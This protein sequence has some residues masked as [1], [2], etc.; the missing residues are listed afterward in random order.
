MAQAYVG[1]VH[2]AAGVPVEADVERLRRGEQ[3]D[4]LL[5][6]VR[7]LPANLPDTCTLL[8]GYTVGIGDLIS[9]MVVEA[10]S[11][12]DLQAINNYY[13]GWFRIDWTPT[14]VVERD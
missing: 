9:F 10:E 14:N 8:A 7:A 1:L 5:A 13:F 6:K 3:L 12:A 4:E 11:Q 2:W